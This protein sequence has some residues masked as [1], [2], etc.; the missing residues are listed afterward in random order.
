MTRRLAC[1]MAIAAIWI[2][3]L[4]WAAGLGW[5]TPLLPAARMALPARDFHVVMGAGVEDGEALQVGAVGGDG[6]ALQAIR[7]AALRAQ[8]F[9]ILRYRFDDFPRTLELSLI[10]RRADA[11]DDVQAVTVPWPGDGW[12]TVDLRSVAEWRGEIVEL[13]FVEYATAQ[14]V[15]PS[16]AFRP[17]RFDRAELMSPSWRGGIAALYTAWFAYVPWALLS[18]SALAPDRATLGTSS[19]LPVMPV[20]LAL[21]LLAAAVILRWSRARLV[22]RLAVAVVVLW[23]LLDWRWLQDFRDRHS[24]TESLY[25]GKSWDER[26]RLL[27]EQDL[28]LAA[29]QIRNWLATQPA[30]PRILVDADSK[31]AYLRLVYLLLPQNLGLLSLS[32]VTLPPTGTLIVLYGSTPWV[33]N[34]ER[35]TLRGTGRTFFVDPAFDSAGARIFR[36]R[37]RR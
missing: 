1:A 23:A 31:Y 30:A 24:V 35:R 3:V 33:Y 9:P 19:P 16:V 4:G 12:R 14:L 36:V 15:P 17:F 18:V 7:I 20:G 22:R 8:D 26:Q 34:A 32:G 25:A 11:P 21:S 29:E 27:P 6:N 10:F 5:N 2:L 13:G 37:N 28:A